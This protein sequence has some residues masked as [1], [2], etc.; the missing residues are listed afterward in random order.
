ME[1]YCQMLRQDL[2]DCRKDFPEEAYSILYFRI[3]VQAAKLNNSVHC[4]VS[5]PAEHIEFFRKIIVRLV[6]AE[7]LP[8]RA[9]NQFNSSFLAKI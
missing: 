7:K 1:A 6:T 2:G 3:F 4:I 8:E 5:L 9:I